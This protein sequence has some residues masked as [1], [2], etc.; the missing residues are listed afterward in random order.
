[1]QPCVVAFDVLF[2][3]DESLMDTPL[4]KRLQYFRNGMIL[5]KEDKTTLVVSKFNLVSTRYALI[6]AYHNMHERAEVSVK[7]C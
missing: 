6:L 3:N 1:M 5:K 2:L 7:D 4:E